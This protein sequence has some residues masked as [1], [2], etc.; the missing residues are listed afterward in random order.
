LRSQCKKYEIYVD[1]YLYDTAL[2]GSRL[3]R[4]ARVGHPPFYAFVEDGRRAVDGELFPVV[5]LRLAT[6]D[7]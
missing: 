5:L 3:Y 7:G 6:T 4:L 1:V 2:V